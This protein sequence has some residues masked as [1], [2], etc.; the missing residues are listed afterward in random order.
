MRS[1]TQHLRPYQFARILP[2]L[3]A[4]LSCTTNVVKEDAISHIISHTHLAY[5]PIH[6]RTNSAS[7]PRSM[8]ACNRNLTSSSSPLD[9]D[10][11]KSFDDHLEESEVIIS[12]RAASLD[13]SCL[14]CHIR[15]HF[16]W[17]ML[18]KDLSSK[19]IQRQ[20]DCSRSSDSACSSGTLKEPSG[21]KD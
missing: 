21:R 3:A 11:S 13:R 16:H 18:E 12:T 7:Q 1:Q 8:Y 17:K 9:C 6:S 20:L 2:T 10:S 14:R 19:W 4:R 15:S 5:T